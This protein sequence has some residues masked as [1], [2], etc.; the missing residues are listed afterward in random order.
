M[1][2]DRAK[3]VKLLQMTRSK[4]DHEALTAV[5]MANDM[6]RVAGVDWTGLVSGSRARVDRR[7]EAPHWVRPAPRLSMTECFDLLQRAGY[8]DG[9]F[10]KMKMQWERKKSLPVPDIKAVHH[11]VEEL[12]LVARAAARAP[13]PQ[14]AGEYD[15]IPEV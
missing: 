10:V 15:E 6:L 9:E 1:S 12:G 8:L 4:N 7:E 5:R 2:L 13:G 3:L 14:V 11:R